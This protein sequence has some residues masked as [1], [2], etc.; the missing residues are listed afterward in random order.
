MGMTTMMTAVVTMGS[1]MMTGE[2]LGCSTETA[3]SDWRG[4]V[5]RRRPAVMGG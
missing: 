1:E 4:Y 3:E 5:T 2:T